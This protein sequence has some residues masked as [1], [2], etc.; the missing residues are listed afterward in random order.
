MT[1]DICK[2]CSEEKELQ[3]SHIIGKAVFSRILKNSDGNAATNILVRE[4]KVFQSNDT[5][6][7]HLLCRECES[8]F[9]SKFEDYSIHVLRKQQ[10]GVEFNLTENGLYLKNVD[11]RRLILYF[12]SIYWRGS[13]STNINY[14]SF[15]YNERIS[16]H[17]KACFKNRSI[18]LSN[19]FAVRV[20]LLKD[21]NGD[22]PEEAFK[23]MLFSPYHRRLD[24]GVLLGMVYEGYLFELFMGRTQMI[25]RLRPGYLNMNNSVLFIPYVNIYE[26]PEVIK[27]IGLGVKI[28]NGSEEEQ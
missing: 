1:L 3:R 10:K 6:D 19:A 27:T 20:R 18:K 11:Q 17:L 2:F 9:N 28:F 23:D 5:W 24:Q 4:G 26:V 21:Y 25:E 15:V 8:F 12:F 7:T 22:I 16:E 13:F 14:E